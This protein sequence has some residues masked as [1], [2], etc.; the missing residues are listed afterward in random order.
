[1]KSKVLATMMAV[2]AWCAPA[3]FSAEFVNL[4]PQPKEMTVG[5][6][7]L[8]L[9]ESVNIVARNLTDE[10]AGEI[11]KFTTTF[12]RATGS[13]VNVT[14]L[15]GG[16]ANSRADEGLFNVSLNSAIHE[17]GYKLNVTA[18]GV[19]IEASAPAGL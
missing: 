3:A 10:M 12:G 18:E 4:T 19:T 7:E 13:K 14:L 6:G 9:P 5:T 17:E 15:S 8:V 2:A 11:T 16:G 1:M